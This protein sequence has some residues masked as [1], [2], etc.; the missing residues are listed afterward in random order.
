MSFAYLNKGFLVGRIEK[1]EEN[2]L[3]KTSYLNVILSTTKPYYKKGGRV[4]YEDV[5]VPMQVWGNLKKEV[6]DFIQ[7]G[8][9]IC[10]EYEP[11]GR[12]WEGKYYVTLYAREII[13]FT[14]GLKHGAVGDDVPLDPGAQTDPEM[15]DDEL[16]F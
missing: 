15:D 8:M 13:T 1:I 2:Q 9:V 4:E 7:S 14:H 11:I 12:E 3:N 16:P 5:L 10:V 6:E